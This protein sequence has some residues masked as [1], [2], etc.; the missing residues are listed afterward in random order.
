[1]KRR[2]LLKTASAAALTAASGLSTAARADGHESGGSRPSY[3]A[4]VLRVPV[5]VPPTADA[6]EDIRR[7]NTEAFVTAI[8]T[9]MKST[10]KPRVISCPVLMYTSARRAVSGVPME[11]VAQDL[12]SKPLDQTIWKPVIDACRRHDCYVATSTQEK[13]PQLPGTYFHTGFIMGPEGLVLRSPKVQA[14][15]APRVSFIR[16][17]LDEYKAAFGPDSILPVA[18]TPLGNF[19][20]YVE[21]EAQV[22]EASRLLSSKGA[23]VILHT[24]LESDAVP[25]VSLKRAIAYQNHVYLLT[26]TTS[27]NLYTEADGSL[28]D[29]WAGGSSTICG[30]AGELLAEMGGRNEGF[31]TAEIDLAHLDDA[32]KEFNRDTVP[33]WNLYTDLYETR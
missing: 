29:D 26:G 1:M 17:I 8:E 28:R 13:V 18:K 3:T 27:R 31:V 12:V 4:A 14:P 25:W 10:P 5:L 23:E 30:P 21:G 7:R 16:D 32:R 11:V 6:L 9:V 2:T 33:A 24:S 15:S 19:A 20:C 22:L